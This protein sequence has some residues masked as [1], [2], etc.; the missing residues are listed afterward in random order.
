VCAGGKLIEGV[1]EALFIEQLFEKRDDR[2]Q[3]FVTHTRLKM[4]QMEEKLGAKE[5]AACEHALFLEDIMRRVNVLDTT[6]TDSMK[7]L[8]DKVRQQGEQLAEQAVRIA[9][10]EKHSMD[11]SAPVKPPKRRVEEDTLKDEEKPEGIRGL[12]K[13]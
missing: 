4:T 2:Y 9:K 1:G 11:F 10:Q 7:K 5:G 6:M 13:V 12:T 8:G 3:E